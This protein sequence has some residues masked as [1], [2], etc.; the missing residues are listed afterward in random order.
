MAETD[1][2]THGFANVGDLSRITDDPFWEPVFVDGS[3]ATFTP[4]RTTLHHHLVARQRVRLR[5]QHQSHVP[6]LQGDRPDPAGALRR[7]SRRRGGGYHLHHVYP[8]A[9]DERFGEYPHAKP[10]IICEYAHAMGNGPAG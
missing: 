4:R 8:R 5:L 7:G 1:V 2:E 10:R 3:S 6:A 9:A